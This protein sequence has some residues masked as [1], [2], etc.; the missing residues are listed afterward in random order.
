M[1]NPVPL[2]Y[3][4]SFSQTRQAMMQQFATGLLTSGDNATDFMRYSEL[5]SVQQN[6]LLEMGALWM[7]SLMGSDPEQP[8]KGDRRFAGEEW[9]KSPY[10]EFLK[11]SYLVNARYVGD[12]IER[13]SLDDRTRARMHFFARQILDVLSPSNHLTTNPQV[14]RRAMETGGDSLATGVKNLLEDL[15]KGR[16]SMTDEQAFEVG[17]NL[18]ITPGSVVF[19]N[20]LIQ[21]IQYQPLTEAVGKRPLVL[22][23]PS[24]NKFYVFDLQPANSFI[25]YAVE[26]GNTV[27]VVSWRN[28]MAEQGH[29][30]WDDYFNE[31]IMRAIDVAL[32]IAAA[33]KVN[34]LGFCVGGTMLGCAAAVMAARREDKIESLTFLTTMLDFTQAGEI[35]LLID[36][37]SVAAREQTIDGG[38]ILPGRELAFVFSTLRGNDLIW[39]YVVGNY[40]EGRQPDAFDILYWNADSTNLPGPMYCWYVRNTYLENNLRGPGQTTQCGVRVDLSAID[41]PTCAGESRGSHRA[42][43]D[44]L[45][46]HATGVGRRAFRARSERSHRRRHQPGSAQQAQLLGRRRAGKTTRALAG[47]GARRAG[48]LVAGLERLASFSRRHA[49]AGTHAPGQHRVSRDRDAARPLR[50]GARRLNQIWRLEEENHD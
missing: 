50:H 40:L 31:G 12:L 45:P 23:S 41:V 37:Q 25:C 30:T 5:A 47:Y 34:A 21:L 39:P 35:A 27:F 43:E 9:K 36:E 42:V 24:I 46:N 14:I 28:V 8:A 44:R 29:L 17:R 49:G 6:Y 15:G 19:E 13:A 1:N 48:K 11:Q 3:A 20:E 38:G 16:I 32:E 7:D 4:T 26:Q 22:F 10:H 18:A 2:E 33:D